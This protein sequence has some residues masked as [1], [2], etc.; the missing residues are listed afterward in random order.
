LNNL[1]FK[2]AGAINNLDGRARTL[3]G[4]LATVA[5]VIAGVI[6]AVAGA[7]AGFL[8]FGGSMSTLI[9]I[10]ASILG[11]IGLIITAIAS[12]PATIVAAIAAIIAFATALIFNIGGARDKLVS[13]LSALADFIVNA[14]NFFAE[15][16]LSSISKLV[17]G[18]ID[19]FNSLGSNIFEVLGNIAS[20]AFDAG[21]NIV[22]NLID[23]MKSILSGDSEISEMLGLDSIETP[24]TDELSFEGVDTSNLSVSQDGFGI[25]SESFESDI[26]TGN[27]SREQFMSNNAINLDGR[28]LSESTGRYRADPSRRRNI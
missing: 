2:V 8:A 10:G 12:L 7:V 22:T 15:N 13:I 6:V 11:V 5:T 21:K 27:F 4:I 1:L 28:Q 17:T 26:N 3:F 20:N 14:F 19:F 24:N 23:G 25:D 16:G 9:T 18:V